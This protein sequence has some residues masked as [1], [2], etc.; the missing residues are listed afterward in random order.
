MKKWLIVGNG[1]YARMMKRYMGFSDKDITSYVVESKY[2]KSE[3]LDDVPVIA[4]EQITEYFP[5]SNV[6][7]VMGIGYRQMG[8]IR[9]QVFNHCKSLGYSFYNYIHPTAIIEQ[10]VI[11]GEG[12]NILEGVIIEESVKIGDANL[13]FGGSIIAHESQ[14]GNF[15]SFSVRSVIAGCT[16]IT[17]NCFIGAGATIRDHIIINEYT[18]IGA[19]SYAN[20]DTKAYSVLAAPKSVLLEGRTSTDYL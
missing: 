4:M 5:P 3:Y 15:N 12:N 20:C 18:L 19:G 11:L 9:R 14:I 13:I 10:N 2:I 8:E 1:S 17:D 6:N 16:N 7:L